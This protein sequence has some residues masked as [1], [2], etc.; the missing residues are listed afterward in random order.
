MIIAKID[1]SACVSDEFI[2][3]TQNISYNEKDFGKTITTFDI[4]RCV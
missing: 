3:K 4:G 1:I 2:E